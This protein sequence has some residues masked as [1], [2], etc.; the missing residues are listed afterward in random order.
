LVSFAFPFVLGSPLVFSYGH[1]CLFDQQPKAKETKGEDV[2]F[3]K[4]ATQL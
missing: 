4:K 2:C 1:H 3:K